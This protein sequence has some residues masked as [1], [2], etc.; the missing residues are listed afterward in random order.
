MSADERDPEFAARVRGIGQKVRHRLEATG[1][2]QGELIERTGL[3]RSYVKVLLNYRGYRD[4]RSGQR[5]P[6]N[7]TIDVI[8]RLAE[9]LEVDPAYLVDLTGDVEPDGSRR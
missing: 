7:P 8:W 5:R 4:P 3:S 2:T 6:P 1:M 9:V